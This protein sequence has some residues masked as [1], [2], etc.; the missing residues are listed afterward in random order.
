[1]RHD[2][3]NT[4]L[5]QAGRKCLLVVCAVAALCCADAA[6]AQS[7]R[8]RSP[9][10][11][12]A[13][14]PTVAAEEKTEA[15]AEAKAEEMAIEPRV[16]ERPVTVSAV[17]VGGNIVTDADYFKS[18]YVDGAARECR[19]RLMEQPVLEVTKGG[20]MTRKEAVVLAKKSKDSYVLW[21][22]INMKTSSMWGD[23]IVS[24]IEYV[25]FKPQT[26]EVLTEGKVNPNTTGIR[27]D[28]DV[29]RVPSVKRRSTSE[30]QQ[31]LEGARIIADR[32][33]VKFVQDLRRM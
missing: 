23:M 25:V 13:P 16:I 9:R 6:L 10:V 27:R 15:K 11:A 4:P 5:T 20:K 7:G 8:R 32:V 26:A 14:A 21:F 28:G 2:S 12:A 22:E 29:V 24:H 33:R 30:M 18:N 3:M 1:V 31:V 17:L 19:D